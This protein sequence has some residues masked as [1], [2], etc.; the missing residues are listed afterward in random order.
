MRVQ[1]RVREM[2]CASLAL[3]DPKLNEEENRKRFGRWSE[4]H[5]HDF[6]VEVVVAGPVDRRTHCVMDYAALRRRLRRE[7][8][9]PLDHQYLNTVEMLKEVTPTSENIARIF[10]KRLAIALPRGV[11]LVSLTLEDG[12]GNAAIVTEE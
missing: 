11:K 6:F 3:R 9:N 12:G 8:I 2:F 7:I 5:G 4:I 10:F 1:I